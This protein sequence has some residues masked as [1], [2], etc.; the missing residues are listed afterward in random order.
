MANLFLLRS[1]TYF[2]F[3]HPLNPKISAL[4]YDKPFGVKSKQLCLE[5]YLHC[6]PT[7]NHDNIELVRNQVSGLN[8]CDR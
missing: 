7:L 3:F 1:Y 4:I 6:R 8:E 5:K 2:L